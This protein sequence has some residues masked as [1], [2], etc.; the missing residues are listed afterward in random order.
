MQKRQAIH[1]KNWQRVNVGTLKNRNT[2][3]W[4]LNIKTDDFSTSQR[5]AD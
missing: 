5:N 1:K 3:K 4:S 2:N